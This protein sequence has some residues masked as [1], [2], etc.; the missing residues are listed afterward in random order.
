MEPGD[1]AFPAL[2]L[3]YA[4]AW[5]GHACIW[6]FLLNNLYGR[7]LPKSLL[8]PWRTFTGVVIL[9]VP[10]FT[11]GR[12]GFDW[13]QSHS[14]PIEGT[15]IWA[16]IAYF[17][18]LCL[19]VGLLIFPIITIRRLLRPRA[20]AIVQE[21]SRIFDPRPHL[22]PK[23]IGNGKWNQLARL[24]FNDIFRVEF[25]EL[26]ITLDRLP[27]AWND[28]SI[29]LLSDLHFHGTPSQLWF[30]SVLNEI[31]KQPTP[32]LVILAGDF[33]D[34]DPHREWI[35]PILG[36]L[37]WTETGLA[38]LGNHDDH[39]G[40]DLIR[41]ELAKLGY[42]VLSNRCDVVT[43]R[44][45]PCEVIGHEGPWF[46]SNL[47]IP[48][49][50]ARFRFCVSHTPDNFYWGQ[51]HSIDLM[52]CGHVHGGQ[53]RLPIIG[54]IFVPSVY[55]RRFDSGVF[56]QGPTVMVVGRGLSGKEPLRFRCLPQ[57]IRMTL[58]GRSRS[59]V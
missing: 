32:D 44:G 43:I 49:A 42:R 29:L 28:L 12:L 27:D 5:I 45:V 24:P 56:E 30:E 26:T 36:R 4:S 47:P 54:P 21:S 38:I 3:V 8:R 40:P 14:P 46:P 1:F 58:K 37:N 19:P 6:T 59:S 22:G 53:I 34:S 15:L 16:L 35:A 51:R 23:L 39:H 31:Q 17:V 41:E 52:L 7:R 13:H 57:V 50:T 2:V 55:S 33:I 9:S 10:I 25:T 48:T 18:I 11:I 20:Q